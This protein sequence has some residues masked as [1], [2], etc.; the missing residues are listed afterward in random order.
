MNFKFWGLFSLIVEYGTLKSNGVWL[1][2]RGYD[3][4]FRFT[5]ND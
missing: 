1:V 2:S 3:I 5:L 4:F